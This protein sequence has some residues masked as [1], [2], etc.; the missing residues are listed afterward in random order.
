M[1]K[2]FDIKVTGSGF[3]HPSQAGINLPIMSNEQLRSSTRALNEAL[4]QGIPQP[5][6]KRTVGRPP[7]AK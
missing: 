5:E 2:D 7:K 1:G 6:K 4:R 3:V